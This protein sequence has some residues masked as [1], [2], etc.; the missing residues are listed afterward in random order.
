MF[1][2][3]RKKGIVTYFI[4]KKRGCYGR[5]MGFW[6]FVCGIVKMVIIL[7]MKF[8][9]VLIVSVGE[10]LFLNSWFYG[11]LLID[12]IICIYILLLVNYSD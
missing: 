5:G 10:F 8:V 4:V 9:V 11:L 12:I 1:G 6:I 2:N 7:L 3:R